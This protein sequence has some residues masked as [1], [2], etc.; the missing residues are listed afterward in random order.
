[1][2]HAKHV[3]SVSNLQ[4]I[5]NGQ[6][7]SYTALQKFGI[8]HKLKFSLEID[9]IYKFHPVDGI[10]TKLVGQLLHMKVVN[11]FFK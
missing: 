9:S 6:L 7:I 11:K 4:T 8:T 2:L 1:M 3:V 5:S 10:K